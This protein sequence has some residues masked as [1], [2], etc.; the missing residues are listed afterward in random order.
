MLGAS[1]AG[2]LG[3]SGSGAAIEPAYAHYARW[4]A[5][6]AAKIS[7]GS[8]TWASS[9]SGSLP[10]ITLQMIDAG[11]NPSTIGY[12][13]TQNGRNVIACPVN[14]LFRISSGGDATSR[15]NYSIIMVACG[16]AGT[17]AR[18]LRLAN[19]TRGFELN[20]VGGTGADRMDF[21]GGSGNDRTM[22]QTGIGL[23]NGTRRAWGI[24]YDG[25]AGIHSALIASSLPGTL[26]AGTT[27]TNQTGGTAILTGGTAFELGGA[28]GFIGD[29]AFDLCE[30]IFYSSSLSQIE[31]DA[32]ISR[33]SSKWGL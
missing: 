30:T 12:A 14:R 1:K 33:L 9:D 21:L 10:T 27:G 16:S 18:P 22:S 23:S 24:S 25:T 17:S 13:S 15:S 6:E 19:V 7:T 28:I 5:G 8:G 4:D 3:A 11:A 26:T 2:L 31:L 20:G 32:E 29:E